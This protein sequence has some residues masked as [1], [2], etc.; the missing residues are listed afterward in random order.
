MRDSVCSE[1]EAREYRCPGE[2]Y[3]ID[4]TVHLGRLASFYSACRD[5]PHAHDTGTLPPS[6]VRRL[7]AAQRKSMP[8]LTFGDDDRARARLDDTTAARVRGLAAAHGV[9]LQQARA[10]RTQ[11]LLAILASD[12]RAATSEA[13]SA[14]S[15]GL[16]WAGCEVIDIGAA[17][18]PALAQTIAHLQADGGLLLGVEGGAAAEVTLSFWRADGE[19]CSTGGALDAVREIFTQRLDRP[20]RSFGGLR[21]FEASE[22]YLDGVSDHFHALRPLRFVLDTSCQP[23]L[24]ALEQLTRNVACEVISLGFGSR[25][26]A[27]RN[28]NATTELATTVRDRR[29]SPPALPRASL[30]ALVAPDEAARRAAALE[31]RVRS[32]RAHFGLAIDAAGEACRM[33]DELGRSIDGDHWFAALVQ[34]WHETHPGMPLTIALEE[35]TSS[36]V[37]VALAA[38]AARV[39]VGGASRQGMHALVRTQ[40]ATLGGGPSGRVWQ[41]KGGVAADALATLGL[42]LAALSQTD[43][44]VS[45]VVADALATEVCPS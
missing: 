35:N 39:A 33:V 4:R 21:R 34:F 43:R 23:L 25:T 31:Q 2:T 32:E 29:R 28:A 5:C 6:V 20:T 12:G 11:P 19:P 14:A 26:T 15:E 9:Y 13:F 36:K 8:P 1:A 40:Q 27:S 38:R 16:R 24:T 37:R 22:L 44:P 18:A 17:A 45:Q 3:S 42:W 30:P 7:R 41:G 10:E